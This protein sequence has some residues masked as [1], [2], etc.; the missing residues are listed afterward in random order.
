MYPSGLFSSSFNATT[1][2]GPWNRSGSVSFAHLDQ[3]RSYM[4]FQTES[5]SIQRWTKFLIIVFQV[6]KT[7]AWRNRSVDRQQN[8]LGQFDVIVVLLVQPIVIVALQIIGV[9]SQTSVS[10]E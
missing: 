9:L 6:T 5:R 7:K 10:I 8:S 1:A 3:R 4:G 2:A